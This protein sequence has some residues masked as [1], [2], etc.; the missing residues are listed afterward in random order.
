MIERV[1]IVDTV[2]D[3][4]PPVE[5]PGPCP[6]ADQKEAVLDWERRM[7]AYGSWAKANRR[8]QLAECLLA[9]GE[10]PADRRSL[11]ERTLILVG[12][13]VLAGEAAHKDVFEMFGFL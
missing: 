2:K 9:L 1:A 3:P 5:D 4:G 8:F 10:V 11:V 12:T 6:P 7:L 13:I